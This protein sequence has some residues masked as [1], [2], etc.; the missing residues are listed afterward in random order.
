MLIQE[1]RKKILHVIPPNRT[2]FTNLRHILVNKLYHRIQIVFGITQEAQQ[3]LYGV[4]NHED[5]VEFWFDVRK[6]L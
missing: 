6:T 1:S 4:I 3:M 2:G 5:G